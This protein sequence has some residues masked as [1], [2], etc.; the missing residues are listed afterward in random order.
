MNIAPCINP[1]MD[2]LRRKPGRQIRDSMLLKDTWGTPVTGKHTRVGEE[3][4]KSHP[5]PLNPNRFKELPDALSIS[6]FTSSL[7]FLSLPI[8]V[9]YFNFIKLF[10]HNSP[11]QMKVTA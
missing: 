4:E 11:F 6:N 2:F 8:P 5:L 9:K 3:A 10:L 1:D 7:H